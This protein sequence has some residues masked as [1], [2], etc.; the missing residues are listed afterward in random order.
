MLLEDATF[1]EEGVVRRHV[2]P[3]DFEAG[4]SCQAEEERQGEDELEQE[5]GGRSAEIEGH[6]RDYL[7]TVPRRSHP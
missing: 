4:R 1:G 6:E 2:D 7:L 5:R 3:E